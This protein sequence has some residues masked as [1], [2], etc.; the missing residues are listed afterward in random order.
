[1][2]LA[3]AES[4]SPRSRLPRRASIVLDHVIE[5]VD[6]SVAHDEPFGH[7]YIENVFPQD[8]YQQMLSQLPD[9]EVY[10]AL[11]P[12]A[13]GRAGG[14]STR[15]RLFLS[16][17][18]LEPLKGE[19]KSCWTT[20]ANI[21][22]SEQL[23]RAVF[24]KLWKDIALRFEVSREDVPDIKTYPRAVLF[25]DTDEYR[26]KPHPDG[27]SRIVTMM[28]YLPRDLSQEDL[29]TS[30]YVKQPPL[31]RLFGEKFKEVK[32]FPFRPNCGYAFVV[33]RLPE[34]TSWHGRELLEPGCGVRNT[35]LTQ[36]RTDPD[37][38]DY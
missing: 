13:Y 2:S 11:N 20:V 37:G 32:R 22:T 6:A 9:N 31:K 18:G 16:K 28:Y 25:R 33:N 24:S 5:A 10:R 35:I 27:E 17:Q 36:F 34:R 26:I 15:D 8:F 12:K 21:I 38:Q 19:M 23:K 3:A 29:G 7:C 1:M 4:A 14:E 30:L